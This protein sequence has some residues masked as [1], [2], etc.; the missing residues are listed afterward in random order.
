MTD[1]AYRITAEVEGFRRAFGEAQTVARQA[2]DGI[3]R[4]MTRVQSTFD[5][6]RNKLLLVTGVLAGGNLFKS[7]ID[8]AVDMQVETE[9]LSRE[10]GITQSRALA[11][12]FAVTDMHV[13]IET[14]SAATSKLTVGLAD[15]GA[16]FEKL[17]ITVKGSNGQFLDLTTIMANANARILQ[18][19]EGV[20]RN[21]VAA[22]VYGK[23]WQ[24][25]SR[26]LTLTESQIDAAAQ[27]VK[28]LGIELDP[29]QIADYR[30][31]MNDARD[32][33]EALQVRIGSQLIPALTDLA[34]W[35]SESGPLASNLFVQGLKHLI[36][37]VDETVLAIRL[38]WNDLATGMEKIAKRLETLGA[39]ARAGATG[40]WD[41]IKQLW[42]AGTAELQA[43]ESKWLAQYY[44]LN[45]EHLERVEKLWG[46]HRKAKSEA[47]P[48]PGGTQS[49]V[50]AL[51]DGKGKPAKT[52]A[53]QSRVPQ[54]E[55]ERREFEVV[56][57]ELARR[58]GQFHQA[59]LTE[60]LLFWQGKLAMAQGGGQAEVAERAAVLAKIYGIKQAQF[61][62]EFEGELA[63]NKALEAE[64]QNNAAR[65][66]A[67]AEQEAALIGQ[68]YGVNSKQYAD[69]EA[70]LTQ[71]KRDALTQRQQMELS[72]MAVERD[73][74]LA[75]IDMA[76]A[77]AQARAQLG[78]ITFGQLLELQEQF[79]IRRAEIRRR[80]AVL[81]REAIDPNGDPLA[82]QQQ[83]AQIQQVELDHQVKIAEIRRQA[84]Q[85]QRDDP[86]AT[87]WSS[88]AQSFDQAVDAMVF[89]GQTLRQSLQNIFRSIFST[90][91]QEMVTKPLMA[92]AM[93]A[94][95]ESAIY[96]AMFGVQQ[97]M[98]Q[99]AA[100]QTV[101]TKSSE[102]LSVVS[103]NAAEGASGAAASQAAI[104]FVGPVLAIAAFAAMM[105][106]IMGAT[107]K[108]K[109]A[110]GG[111]SI[112]AGVNPMTQLHEQEM[113][114]PKA[115]ANAVRE[116]ARG[117][118][119]AK[120]D[121]VVVVNNFM[122][123]EET[124]ERAQEQIARQA[125][126]AIMSAMNRI[127]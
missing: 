73:R 12:R 120:T 67:I 52:P 77:D 55:T 116:M 1:F 105:A 9:K 41:A 71:I 76:E 125:G 72:A 43:M 106:M 38:V 95:R 123:G 17:G 80:Y 59:S 14:L 86:S 4:E 66:V 103:A 54:W 75:S 115:E 22:Q 51:S 102:A 114:L 127:G 3:S 35:F 53:P 90:F 84:V 32:V 119:A 112:P 63:A 18:M 49:A 34:R 70:R 94:I 36:Q 83:T 33:V 109:S 48:P 89:K 44:R 37:F 74:M 62:Q 68:R 98:Q 6:L 24:E 28:D 82:Y 99:S 29:Q 97:T 61:R 15:G 79:E 58:Q 64:A 126:L 93:R 104:P 108:I 65:R 91:M 16:K 27:K 107:S 87:I 19:K 5:G 45:R 23:S 85:A 110:A 56:Q 118:S 31:A 21:A 2:S 92:A 57:A 26:I 8:A 39:I 40:Q 96:Q 122:V 81:Q 113:V 25:V 117:K 46:K 78:Q 20:D 13:P 42:Q 88:A 124:G 11:L 111:Y 30:N 10:F 121:G 50:D 100:Q 101:S 7:T 47:P 60:E 69:A